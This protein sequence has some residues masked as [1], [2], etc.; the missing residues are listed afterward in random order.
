MW[1]TTCSRAPINCAR[2]GIAVRPVQLK[3]GLLQQSERRLRDLQIDGV[4][5]ADWPST[6]ALAT[7][8]DEMESRRW[9]RSAAGRASAASPIQRRGLRVVHL[10]GRHRRVD[11]ALARSPLRMCRP[12]PVMASR[13]TIDHLTGG[14]SASTSSPAGTGPRSRCSASRRWSTTSATIG[15][16]ATSSS[17]SCG[18]ARRSSIS[19]AA[20]TPSRRGGWAPSRCRSPIRR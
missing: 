19:T 9:C 6:L 4:L 16:M 1:G 13:T 11:E 17:S 14:R 15:R 5:K 10:G 12:C 20:T 7:M 2:P 8:A 18:P 3:L